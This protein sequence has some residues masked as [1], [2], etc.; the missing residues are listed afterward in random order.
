VHKIQF[1]IQRGRY[2]HKSAF[3]V[4]MLKYWC[5]RKTMSRSVLRDSR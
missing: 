1:I 5:N 3:C 4:V 2:E